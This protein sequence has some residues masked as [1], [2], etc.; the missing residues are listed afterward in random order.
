VITDV[1]RIDY[2]LWLRQ[3]T[4][5]SSRRMFEVDSEFNW[6]M[7]SDISG[8]E[9]NFLLIFETLHCP[10]LLNTANPLS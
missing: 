8:Y 5:I 9:S 6:L 3:Y 7:L 1:V 4:Y 2:L 10:T